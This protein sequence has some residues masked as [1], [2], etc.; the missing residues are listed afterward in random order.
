MTDVIVPIYKGVTETLACLTSLAC[1][2]NDTGHEVI[3][4]LDNPDDRH[5]IDEVLRFAARRDMTVLINERNAGFVKSAN[6]GMR[7]H[8]DRDVVLLNADTVVHHDWLDRLAAAARSSPDIGTVTPFSNNA[9]IC[10]YPRF[11]EDNP[12]PADT[13]GG[14]LDLMCRAVN[15]GAVADIP[16]AVGFCMYIR[17]DC[18]EDSGYFD[19]K[20]FGKGYGEEN[21]FCRRA[22]SKGWRNVLAADVFIDHLGS[23]SFRE[24]KDALTSRNLEV[25]TSMHPTYQETVAAFIRADPIRRFRRRI[26]VK[27]VAKSGRPVICMVIHDFDGGAAVHV[28]DLA[29]R[30]QKAGV[31]T[32]IARCSSTGRVTLSARGLG[33]TPNLVYDMPRESAELLADIMRLGVR[34]FHFHSNINI[35]EDVLVL[36]ARCGAAYDCTIHDYAWI[37][38]RVHLADESRMYCGAPAAAECERCVAVSGIHPRWNLPVTGD[39]VEALRRRSAAFLLGA[40]RVFCPSNDVLARLRRHIDLRNGAV[41]GHPDPFAVPRRRP[42]QWAPGT[43]LRVAVIGAIG[44]EKGSEVLLGCARHAHENRLPVEFIIIGYTNDNNSFASLPNVTITGPYTPENLVPLLDRYQPHL[45]FFPA[46]VPETFSYTLSVA[47]RCG[48]FPVAFDIGAISERIRSAACGEILP[49]SMCQSP[50]QVNESL[51]EIATGLG[52]GTACIAEPAMYPDV[53][54]DYYDLPKAALLDVPV[55]GTPA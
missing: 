12:I 36:P 54:S 52:K 29:A 55:C 20:A 6:R 42:S 47:F 38:P 27:R 17:R 7:L 8:P 50:G 45:S 31:G 11:V 37:C 23:V 21:D 53:I 43:P 18:L 40:R 1:A 15:S 10:S 34:H 46:V 28:E 39:T 32:L 30:L 13:R 16:T 25:L 9:T 2:V 22:A 19:E 33:G 5:M 49:L 4:I 41:R 48:L 35:P 24:I 44:V 51:L 3:C 26:D 14:G